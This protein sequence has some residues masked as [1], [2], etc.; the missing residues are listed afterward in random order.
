MDVGHRVMVSARDVAGMTKAASATTVTSMLRRA[1]RACMS[2]LLI[3]S[4]RGKQELAQR[5]A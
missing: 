5:S 3:L 2:L 4:R 1:R